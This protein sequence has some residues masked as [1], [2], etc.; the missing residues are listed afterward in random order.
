MT[1]V[2]TPQHSE[3]QDKLVIEQRLGRYTALGFRSVTIANREGRN[4]PTASGDATMKYH[5][6]ELIKQSR[7]FYNNNEIYRGLI[8]RAVSYIVSNGFTLQIKTDNAGFNQKVEQGLWKPFMRRPEIRGLLSGSEV[9]QMILREVILC[10]DNPAYKTN[11]GVLQ[12]FEAEQLDGGRQSATGVE[13]DRYNRPMRFWLSPYGEHGGIKTH[14]AV[15]FDPSQILFV[16]NP[17]RP[18][19]TRGIPA[20]QAAFPMLHRINDIC[21]SEAIAW[22]LLAR[23]AVS[24]NRENAEQKAWMQSKENPNNASD[25]SGQL[26]TRLTELSYALMFHA[27][28]GEEIKGIDHNIPG[29]NFSESLRMFLRLLGLPLGLPLELV[30]LDW[31]RSNYSQSRA[32]LEQAYQMFLFWQ[33]KMEDFFYV[34]LVEWKMDQWRQSNLLG[35]RK[36]IPFA[37]I[38]PTFPW[39]DQLKEAQAKASMVEH[40]FMTHAEVCKS[41]GQ[42]RE[43]VV[44][45][46]EKEIREAI[47]IAQK[48]QTDTGIAVPW[49]LFAGLELPKAKT[50]TTAQEVTAAVEDAQEA[51]DALSE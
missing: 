12:L 23:L 43:E 15:K 48:I 49:E 3:P 31:T 38:R 7:W 51:H 22:Q 36:Q 28:P 39:I 30:L 33:A 40:C 42:D 20:M 17:D 26:A 47:A 9:A 32:V 29:K 24:I 45:M 46:R 1:V 19:A 13:T 5:R 11:K 50:A 4:Y 6:K 16:T 44:T 34:P 14:Q 8:D 27:N 10:G 41:R 18:S 35:N 25:T 21:D 37:F 2:R